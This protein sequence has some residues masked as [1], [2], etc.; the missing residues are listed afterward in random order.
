MRDCDPIPSFTADL[1]RVLL[2]GV[3]AE[4]PEVREL[5][6]GSVVCFCARLS[7]G[8]ACRVEV[9]LH[10]ASLRRSRSR[11]KGVGLAWDGSRRGG[12]VRM[13]SEGQAIPAASFRACNSN[14]SGGPPTLRSTQKTKAS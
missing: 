2:V 10:C 7:L 9:R 4:A 11:P 8:S 13:A 5:V 14:T 3:L 1:N 6:E 12:C